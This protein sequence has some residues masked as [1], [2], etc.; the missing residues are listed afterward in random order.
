MIVLDYDSFDSY[1][2]EGG[3]GGGSSLTPT[4]RKNLLLMAV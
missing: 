4:G 2:K 3:G 1:S